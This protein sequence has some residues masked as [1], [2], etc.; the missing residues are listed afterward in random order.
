M[1]LDIN[2]EPPRKTS[3]PAKGV[4]SV[5]PDPGEHDDSA[6]VKNPK[7]PETSG[8]SGAERIAD[9]AAHKANRREQEAEKDGGI[10]TH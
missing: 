5:R 8:S 6:T 2:S 3:T 7:T 9:R 10:V 4:D 1:T